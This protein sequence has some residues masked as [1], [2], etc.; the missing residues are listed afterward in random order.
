[1]I[2]FF[3]PCSLRFTHVHHADLSGEQKDPIKYKPGKGGAFERIEAQFRNF[4]SQDQNS[5]FP[6]ESGRY[7]LYVSPGC[8]WVSL[9]RSAA[10]TRCKLFLLC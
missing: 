4:I 9:I 5:K 10:G 7:A 2:V 3:N 8:P 1:M 6:A